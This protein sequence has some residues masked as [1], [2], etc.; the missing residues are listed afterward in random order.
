MLKL[1]FAKILTPGVLVCAIHL[2]RYNPKPNA[3]A[4]ILLMVNVQEMFIRNCY[5]F[6][7]LKTVLGEVHFLHIKPHNKDIYVHI[8]CSTPLL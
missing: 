6:I 3:T 5:L 8:R 4:V 1:T 2:Y 7:S